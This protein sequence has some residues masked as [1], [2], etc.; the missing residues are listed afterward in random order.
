MS[1][2]HITTTDTGVVFNFRSIIKINAVVTAAIMA[3]NTPSNLWFDNASEFVLNMKS[4]LAII[5]TPVIV[6][7]PVTTCMTVIGSLSMKYAN[8]VT[9]TGDEK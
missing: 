2:Y 5:T 9:K 4:G 6:R 7:V 8:I 1:E 3:S